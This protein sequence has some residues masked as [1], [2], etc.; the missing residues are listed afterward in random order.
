[1]ALL[2]FKIFTFKIDT[3]LHMLEPISEIFFQLWRFNFR[4]KSL[5][6]H[7]M[8]DIWKQ[9]LGDKSGEYESSIRRTCF[10]ASVKLCEI[11]RLQSFRTCKWSCFLV[12][13]W[14]SRSVILLINDN[15]RR[16]WMT[17]TKLVTEKVASMLEFGKPI[18]ILTVLFDGAHLQ[19]PDGADR[20]NGKKSCPKIT[21]SKIRCK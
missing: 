8:F 21:S 20:C 11:Q 3:L 18:V 17:F 19:G 9:S 7:L 5:T 12:N 1:M 13:A 10:R 6:T 14:I 16:E 4:H 15:N 2:F